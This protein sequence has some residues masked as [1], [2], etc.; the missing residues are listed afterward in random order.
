M[1]KIVCEKYVY[2]EEKIY[3]I[4]MEI[5]GCGL[6]WLG[7]GKESKTVSK[8]R[9]FFSFRK[10]MIYLEGVLDWIGVLY[11]DRESKKAW[12]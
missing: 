6:S 8:K 1:L 4:G 7:N 9:F 5:Y 3:R 12:L 11:T 10:F 2:I